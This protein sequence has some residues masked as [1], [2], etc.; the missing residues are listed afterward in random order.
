[1]KNVLRHSR[2]KRES[3]GLIQLQPPF[4]D[5][6]HLLMKSTRRRRSR[7]VFLILEGCYSLA[8]VN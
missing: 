2:E 8:V 5:I 6:S 7:S 3:K 4:E 1:M